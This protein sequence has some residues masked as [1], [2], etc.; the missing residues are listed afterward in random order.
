[1]CPGLETYTYLNIRAIVK[2]PFFAL[3]KMFNLILLIQIYN[4]YN[5][6]VGERIYENSLFGIGGYLKILLLGD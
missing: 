5:I 2:S 4:I 6:R 1:M 3:K